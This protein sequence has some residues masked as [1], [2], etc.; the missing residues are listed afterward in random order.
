[1]HIR[2]CPEDCTAVSVI[3]QGTLHRDNHA[4]AQA[5]SYPGL[6]IYMLMEQP[7][8]D[9]LPLDGPSHSPSHIWVSAKLALIIL[10]IIQTTGLMVSLVP[11]LR[12]V[13]GHI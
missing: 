10:Y 1:M 5:L 8:A 2:G 9:W 3:P 7:R 6:S 13:A 12:L 11:F 4:I